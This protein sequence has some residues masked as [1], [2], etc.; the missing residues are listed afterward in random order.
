VTVV[1]LARSFTC[2]ECGSSFSLSARNA[3][4]SCPRDRACLPG[5]PDPGKV[6]QRRRA[7]RAARWWLEDSGLSLVELREIA[8]SLW[9][10]L[11]V[12]GSG[13]R[14]GEGCAGT[15]VGGSARAS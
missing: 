1:E 8:L 11:T 7:A 2:P 10:E 4:P 13:L 14:P 15:V 12:G 6:A 5:M 3:R 9:P